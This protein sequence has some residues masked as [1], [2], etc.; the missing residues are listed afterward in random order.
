MHFYYEP[1]RAVHISIYITVDQG[2]LHA[3]LSLAAHEQQLSNRLRH[4]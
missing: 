1:T 3:I 2:R 4:S